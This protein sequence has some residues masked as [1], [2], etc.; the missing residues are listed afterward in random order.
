VGKKKEEKLAFYSSEDRSATQLTRPL[1]G[2]FGSLSQGSRNG[3]QDFVLSYAMVVEVEEDPRPF[4]NPCD[5][6]R[7]DFDSAGSLIHSFVSSLA[8]CGLER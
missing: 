1:Y 7:W 3:S 8:V 6:G 5:W 2:A 4:K